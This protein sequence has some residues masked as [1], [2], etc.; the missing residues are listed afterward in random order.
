VPLGSSSSLSARP[1]LSGHASAKTGCLP[2]AGPLP[3]GPGRWG[4]GGGP[5]PGR[6][7][8]FFYRDPALL[9]SCQPEWL[10]NKVDDMVCQW[11]IIMIHPVLHKA[12]AAV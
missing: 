12:V 2:R 7:R 6:G 5:G 4:L 9:V 1:P 8:L 3:A 11:P 10:K